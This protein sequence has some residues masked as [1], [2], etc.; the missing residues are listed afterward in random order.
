MDERRQKK[1]GFLRAAAVALLVAAAVL[2]VALAVKSQQQ[3]GIDGVWDSIT[4]VERAEAFFYDNAAGGSFAWFDGGLAVMSNAGLY[5]YDKA[6]ELDFS[7]LFTYSSPAMSVDGGYGAAYDT[8]GNSVIFFGE[9]GVIEDV[10]TEERVVSATVNSSG[11][12]AVSTEESGYFGSVTVYNS[13]GTAIYR[14]MAGAG[15]VLLARVRGSDRMLAVTIGDGGSRI[16]EYTFDSTDLA[17]EYTVDELVID[18]LYTDDGVTL[19]TT[20]G[21]I[22]L[23]DKLAEEWRYDFEG[24]YLKAY[25]LSRKGA[26]LAL[27]D[28]QVGGGGEIVS[29]SDSGKAG[30]S[31][32]YVGELDSLDAVSSG[33]VALVSGRVTRYDGDLRGVAEFEA[34]PGTERVLM[35]TDGVLCAGPFSAYLH[36]N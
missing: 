31:A 14:W 32:P 36:G 26:T 29:V 20:G 30:G 24:R 5:V 34:D 13:A 11:Y 2:A 18:A 21:L 33:A 23:D 12:L 3:G 4:G 7:R 1:R 22:G 10:V 17:H 25:V 9:D 27:A 19:V 15:R 28:F 16:V 6:G 8:G 35:W